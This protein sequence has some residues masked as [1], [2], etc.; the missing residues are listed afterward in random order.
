MLLPRP[1]GP[2][3]RM[4][5]LKSPFRCP[6]LDRYNK[7][8][9]TSNKYK[10][11]FLVSC[12]AVVY[13]CRPDAHLLRTH[14][15]TLHPKVTIRLGPDHRKTDIRSKGEQREREDMIHVG[16]TIITQCVRN[17][18][19]CPNLPDSLIRCPKMEMCR[20]DH[21]LLS[22]LNYFNSDSPISNFP[23]RSCTHL[24]PPKSSKD[25]AV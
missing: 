12:D 10:I 11:E 20:W 18:L 9:D 15:T 7:K 23:R 14:S 8:E 3:R 24:V 21:Y 16:K 4:C 2:H 25:L 6:S 17:C 13:S 22:V 19:N 5:L 1:E